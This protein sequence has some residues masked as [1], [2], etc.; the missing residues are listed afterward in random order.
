M[1]NKKT[2]ANTC[3]NTCENC[4]VCKL[5]K[6]KYTTNE[7]PIH[8]SEN[9]SGK[10]SGIGCVSTSVVEN[11]IC[12][13]RRKVK[14]SIC[15]KCFAAAL[16]ARY[17]NSPFTANL[18]DNTI[19]LTRPLVDSEIPVFNKSVV[20]FRFESFGD[21]NNATQAANYLRIAAA[22]P[23]VNFAVWTKNP[24]HY[25]LAI[26][27]GAVKPSNLNIIYSSPM[28]NKPEND[29]INRFPFIDKVFTVYDKKTIAAENIDI[30]C[31]ARSCASCG[32]CYFNKTVKVV[33][34]KLK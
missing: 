24:K 25:E 28:L 9:M 17:N 26:A 16:A 22:N 21:T 14:G 12:Q 7:T 3:G 33:S 2:A 10:M 32:L 23:H 29:I 5:Y 4:S 15:E 11:P 27:N 20:M 1:A 34:E 13:E 6:S 30:N 31:G 8:I 19:T 18:H